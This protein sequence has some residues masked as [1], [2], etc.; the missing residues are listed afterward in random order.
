MRYC[1]THSTSAAFRSPV[2]I[3][4][5]RL[6]SRGRA[7]WN[8]SVAPGVAKP[9]S[10]FN[11]RLTGTMVAT[12]DAERQLEMQ[13]RRNLLEILAEAL[14]DRDRVARHRVIGRPAADEHQRDRRRRAPR[15]AT[16]RPTSLPRTG[17]SPG[18]RARRSHRCWA[19]ARDPCH[20]LRCVEPWH[21]L[22]VCGV[23]EWTWPATTGA[24]M[25]TPPLAFCSTTGPAPPFTAPV[26]GDRSL[27]APGREEGTLDTLWGLW[28]S[29][30]GVGK[31][32]EKPWQS[33]TSPSTELT[34]F[35]MSRGAWGKSG[36]LLVAV[37]LGPRISRSWCTG[38]EVCL[39][40]STSS[41]SRY[42]TERRL[43]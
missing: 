33:A 31:P 4:V 9:N 3:C 5:S 10:C 32:M 28:G 12:I 8:G 20:H 29:P 13:A 22:L 36:E 27:R 6:P 35:S 26:G 39:P 18:G 25:L 23:A 21:L 17:L 7:P 41:R 40:I 30:H 37:E 11:C 14:D 42:R 15:R 34:P 16:R 38:A 1:T 19:S 24:G 43:E 2:T